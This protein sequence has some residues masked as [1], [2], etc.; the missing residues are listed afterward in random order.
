MREDRFTLG[1][2]TPASHCVKKCVRRCVKSKGV[3]PCVYV[4]AGVSA[5]V[6][7]RDVCFDVFAIGCV[8][9]DVA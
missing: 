8:T 2:V 3:A 4:R 5:H 6:Y 9:H 1:G 7:G